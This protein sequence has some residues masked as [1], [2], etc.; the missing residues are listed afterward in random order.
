M[1]GIGVN[2]FLSQVHLPEKRC[3]RIL[4]TEISLN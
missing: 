3:R 2:F 4:L 1:V